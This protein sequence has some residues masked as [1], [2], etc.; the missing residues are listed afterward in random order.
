[1]AVLAGTTALAAPALAAEAP[2]EYELKA[3]LLYNFTQFV[4]WP[5]S[6]FAAADAPLTIGIL[7]R[8]PFGEVIDRLVQGEE[9]GSHRIVVQ[10]CAD[11]DAARRC[12]VLFI[13]ASEREDASRIVTAL[14]GRAVL[15][16]GDFDGFIRRGGMVRFYSVGKR[17]RLRV[18]R[19]T[20]QAAGLTMSAKLL[21]VVELS[22]PGGD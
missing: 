8:D 18:D 11:L 17:I 9:S 2:T 16:V 1:M 10:R 3:A 19:G 7:G 12:Q 20:V 21:R 13:S 6:A 15:T 14:S 22:R 4:E 5:K